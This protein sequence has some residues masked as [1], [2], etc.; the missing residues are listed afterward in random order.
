MAAP[1]SNAKL[2][3]NLANGEPST[4]GSLAA[5][6]PPQSHT[7]NSRYP[8]TFPFP[9]SADPTPTNPMLR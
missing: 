5:V 6:T 3:T 9:N 1:T 8:T 2:N 4:H 7:T